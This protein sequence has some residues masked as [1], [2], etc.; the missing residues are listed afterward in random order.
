MKYSPKQSNIKFHLVCHSNQTIFRIQDQGIGIPIKDQPYL[1]SSFYRGSNT[2]KISGTG[3]G[4]SIVK[5]CVDA[6][7][8]TISFKSEEGVGTIVTVKLCQ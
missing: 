6:H 7:H 3:L 2:N 8:G 5:Q 4:L 1:F